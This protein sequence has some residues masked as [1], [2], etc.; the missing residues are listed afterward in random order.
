MKPT[1]CSECDNQHPATRKL[2][3]EQRLCL[4][5]PRLEGGNG[6]VDPKWLTENEPYMR[7]AKINGGACVCFMPLRSAEKKWAEGQ[8]END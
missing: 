6:F 4:M 7:C 1:L 5:F 2:H 8:R 3:P